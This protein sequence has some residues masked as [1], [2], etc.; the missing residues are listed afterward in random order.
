MSM[1]RATNELKQM[2]EYVD[3]M[4]PVDLGILQF[5]ESHDIWIS[6]ADL[7]KNIDYNSEYLGKRLR[8]LRDSG[9]LKQDGSTYAL[10]DTG[11]KFVSGELSADEVTTPEN[12]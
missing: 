4:K 9:F 5:Y 8:K 1:V 3:W 2:V 11:R 12:F 10:T 7:S 6:A